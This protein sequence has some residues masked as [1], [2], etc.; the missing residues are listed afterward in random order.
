VTTPPRVWVA[1]HKVVGADDHPQASGLSRPS[2]IQWP[3]SSVT[4]S[5]QPVRPG[6]SIPHPTAHTRTSAHTS[7][8]GPRLSAIQAPRRA[9]DRAKNPS[10]L[11]PI[12]LSS[13]CPAWP[14]C[15]PSTR[16]CLPLA[17]WCLPSARLCPPSVWLCH[18][19]CGW[20]HPRRGGVRPQHGCAY[21]SVASP[22]ALEWPSPLAWSRWRACNLGLMKILC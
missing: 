21:P 4:L 18:P 16:L 19:W 6:P 8:P 14:W 22:R 1:L 10:H 2:L 15:S 12:S 3:K 7:A 20:A 17:W 11:S 5:R 13:L 9:L